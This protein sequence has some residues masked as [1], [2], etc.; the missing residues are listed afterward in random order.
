MIFSFV[1]G[2]VCVP[3][4]GQ[5]IILNSDIEVKSDHHILIKKYIQIDR[6]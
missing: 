4:N 5:H 6:R 1:N 3:I 2:I